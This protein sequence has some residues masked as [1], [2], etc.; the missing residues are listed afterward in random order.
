MAIVT[1]STKGSALTHEEVDGN[2]N[3]LDGRVEDLETGLGGDYQF[4]KNMNIIDGFLTYVETVDGTWEDGDPDFEWNPPN[5]TDTFVVQVLVAQTGVNNPF[6]FGSI[7]TMRYDTVL[8]EWTNEWSNEILEP[9][10]DVSDVVDF[11]TAGS[12]IIGNSQ[13]NLRYRLLVHKV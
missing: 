9:E 11:S 3:D 8:A 6:I 10:S 2:F 5:V 1:R 12:I 7:I 13:V 4:L